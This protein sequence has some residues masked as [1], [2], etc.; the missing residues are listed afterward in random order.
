MASTASDKAAS[1]TT[2]D[3]SEALYWLDIEAT[4]DNLDHLRVMAES[5]NIYQEREAARG[6]LWKAAGASDSAHHLKSKGARV[7]HAVD[8]AMPEA[9]LDDAHDAVNYAVFYVRN[10]RAGRIV[11]D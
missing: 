4:E 7:K 9:G 2:R 10:V 6:G 5:M 1:L 3:L 8:H 11:E